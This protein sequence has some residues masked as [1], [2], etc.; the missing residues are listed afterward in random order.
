MSIPSVPE[1]LY[2]EVAA[3]YYD[4]RLH[5]TSA[6][7]R[8]AS[9]NLVARLIPPTGQGGTT[10][11]DIGAG[12][13]LLDEAGVTRLAKVCFAVD[14]SA[15]MLAHSEGS[16]VKMLRGRAQELPIRG[17]TCDLLVYSLA[18]P[19]N[20]LAT[21][22]E[23]RRVL[24]DGGVAVVTMPTFEWAEAYRRVEG[25][26]VHVSRFTLVDGR[27]IAARSNVLAREEQR[28]AFE[29]CGLRVECTEDFYFSGEEDVPK[30]KC[31]GLRPPF[32]VVRGWVCRIA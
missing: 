12:R 13:T 22:R 25:S 6:Y 18:D 19:Y 16:G 20:E 31:S 7:F 10:I 21:W 11:G 28:D 5:P 26:P 3:E 8:K 15:G 32:P 30:L 2:E 1:R 14:F 4:A 29:S 27:G 24:S 23:A 9:L 17:G